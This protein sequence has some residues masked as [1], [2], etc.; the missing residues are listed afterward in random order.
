[1]KS[2]TWHFVVAV[3]GAAATGA[4]CAQS[5]PVSAVIDGDAAANTAGRVAVNQASGAGNVQAN[6]AAVSTGEASVVSSQFVGR[7]RSGVSA[8]S[9]LGG[10][11]FNGAAGLV[12]IN[13]ASGAGNAQVNAAVIAP[14]ASVVQQQSHHIEPLADSALSGV[15]AQSRRQDAAPAAEARQDASIASTALRN[16]SGV[17]QVNQTAGTGNVVSNVFVLRPPAGTLF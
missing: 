3:L 10:A 17:V 7:V 2:L 15:A 12:S 14:N 8:S 9:R 13:Q 1:M 6:V 11:S 5:A 4:A 16:T